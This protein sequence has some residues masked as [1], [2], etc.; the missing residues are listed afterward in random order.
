M[1]DSAPSAILK[2]TSPAQPAPAPPVITEVTFPNNDLVASVVVVPP[3]VDVNAAIL[4]APLTA[5][6]VRFGPAGSDL[7]TQ[8]FQEFPGSYPPGS[9]ATVE[10]TVPAW[11]TAYDFEAEVSN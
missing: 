6:K 4:T 2:A 1:P 3:T 7:S 10:V 9:L 8:P 5:V 11:S